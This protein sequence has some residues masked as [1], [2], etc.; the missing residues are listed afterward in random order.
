MRP[1]LLIAT[2]DGQRV[3][4]TTHTA[5]SWAELQ[6][7]DERKRLLM[8]LCN[9]RAVAKTRGARTRYFAHLTKRDCKAEHGGETAQHLAMKEALRQCIDKVPGWHAFVEH[10]HP[11]REWTVD[12][13]AESDDSGAKVALEVQLS[14][15]S[16]AEYFR[17]TQRY[18]D[19][20][21]FPVWLVPRHL[22]PHE[23]KVP[24]VVTGYGKTS[25][26]PTDVSELLKLPADQD[27]VNA[28]D[29]LG[30]FVTA[31]LL[32]GT[33]WKLGSP[34]DQ[35]AR[36]KKAAEREAAQAEAERKKQ[37]AIEQ[38]IAEMNDRSASPESAFGHHMVCTDTQTFVWGSLTACR[39][40]EEPM[41]VWDAR[42]P[43]FRKRWVRVPSVDVKSDVG[44]ERPEDEAEVHRVVD[45]WITAT[46]ADIP[47]AGIRL[48]YTAASGKQYSAF[49]CPACDNVMRQY[50]VSR[51]LPEKWS[52]LSG[53]A[54]EPAPVPAAPAGR[55]AGPSHRSPAHSSAPRGHLPTGKCDWC[56]KDPHP[57]Y[58]CLWRQFRAKANV[59]DG[60]AHY[61]DQ[62]YSR[63]VAGEKPEGEG[64]EMLRRMVDRCVAI[65]RR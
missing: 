13:L 33:P 16:P 12:V 50:F 59:P 44:R 57:E 20:G 60:S 63:I 56:G 5:E 35:A 64:A 62:T 51:I 17:R 39:N 52:L 18:F 19:S 41:L 40:C 26:V 24:V 15:Q 48:R 27:I 25:A 10:Q 38:S 36:R 8:P 4:A 46:R 30:A 53:P 37:D 28:D 43:G 34:R 58:E 3:D 2:L 65:P 22:E 54:V 14:S 31:L 55:V 49:F 7:S 9:I 32:R 29:T 42:S 11:S 47:K 21:L 1:V 45:A 6:E 23:I 61:S